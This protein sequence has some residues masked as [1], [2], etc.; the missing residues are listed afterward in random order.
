M[1]EPPSPGGLLGATGLWTIQLEG[2][3]SG[4]LRETVQEIEALG[5]PALW[6]PETFGREAL[7]ASALLLS[8]TERLVV[9]TGIATIWGRDPSTAAMGHRTLTEAFPERFA[10]GLG[11]SHPNLVGARGHTWAKPVTAMREYLDTMDMIQY[12]S[13]QPTTA[14]YRLLAALQPRMLALSAE[15]AAGAHTYLV[16]PEHTAA[17]REIL[18]PNPVLAPEQMVIL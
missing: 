6:I 15:R 8:A 2:L 9:V 1:T 12:R 16:T 3:P 17:A 13:V 4:A 11:I 18:G 14:M 7:S 5:W 10:F